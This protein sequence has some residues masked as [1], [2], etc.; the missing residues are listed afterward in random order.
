MQVLVAAPKGV[1]DRRVAREAGWGS[2]RWGYGLADPARGRRRL[3]VGVC[4]CGEWAG[5]LGF[6]GGWGRWLGEAVDWGWGLKPDKGE[7]VG[8]FSLA[9]V[10]I[11]RKE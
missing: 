1:D 7:L 6:V 5:G 8:G 9:V 11:W 4:E 3:A 10:Q 2:R